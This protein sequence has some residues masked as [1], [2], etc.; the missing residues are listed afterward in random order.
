MLFINKLKQKQCSKLQEVRFKEDLLDAEK[1]NN[2]E[3]MIV[4]L[5]PEGAFG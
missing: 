5:I 1:I 3:K 2:A 4:K